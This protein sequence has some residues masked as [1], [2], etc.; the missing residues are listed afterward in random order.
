MSLIENKYPPEATQDS[1]Q[2][3]LD[4]GLPEVPVVEQ[5]SL[6][7]EIPV[8]PITEATPHKPTRKSAGKAPTADSQSVAAGIAQESGADASPLEHEPLPSAPIPAARVV[9][10]RGRAVQSEAVVETG[11]ADALAGVAEALEMRPAQ[12]MAIA[13]DA[14]QAGDAAVAGASFELPNPEPKPELDLAPA[15][16]AMASDDPGKPHTSSNDHNPQA[17]P[18]SFEETLMPIA[19]EDRTVKLAVWLLALTAGFGFITM[20]C[21]L[22][23]LYILTHPPLEVPASSPVAAATTSGDQAL[24][25]AVAALTPAASVPAATA[26]TASAPA[27]VHH[28]HH[29]K[30]KISTAA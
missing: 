21:M 1:Q 7:P 12:P 11:L 19:L 20:V 27:A 28:H 24:A 2:G 16:A 13:G 4:L 29:H 5:P 8:L 6:T 23:S 14:S 18:P 9:K 30:P 22:W 25:S 15:L 3:F 26:A 10:R 17:I